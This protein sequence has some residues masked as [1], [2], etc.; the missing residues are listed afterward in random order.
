MSLPRYGRATLRGRIGQEAQERMAISRLKMSKVYWRDVAVTV[1]PFVL[2]VVAAFWI[3]FRYVRPAP[4]RTIVMTSGT[5]GSTFQI[6][7]ERYREI[8]A[9]QGV[10]LKIIPSQG[11]LENLK[12]LS[13]PKFKAD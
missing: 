13:D 11:S 4:P 8:L 12:R 9:R 10:T 6:S 5:E 3:A 2:L 1:G 7:A